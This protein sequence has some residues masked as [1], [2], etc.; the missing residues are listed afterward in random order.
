MERILDGFENINEKVSKPIFVG[1]PL[2]YME[3]LYTRP[4]QG[5]YIPWRK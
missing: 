4:L 3:P 5:P 1:L 2:G